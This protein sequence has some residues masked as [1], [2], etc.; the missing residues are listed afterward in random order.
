MQHPTE[1]RAMDEQEHA[2]IARLDR[3]LAE[4]REA[5]RDMVEFNH[6][7]VNDGDR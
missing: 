1:S 6:R 5:V 4:L 7:K 3:A 2:Q